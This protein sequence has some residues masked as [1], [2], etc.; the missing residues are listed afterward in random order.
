MIWILIVLVLWIG[1]GLF[2]LLQGSQK[3]GTDYQRKVSRRVYTVGETVQVSLTIKPPAIV[4]ASNHDVILAIDDSDSMGKAPGSPLR[5]VIRAAENFIRLLPES[6]HIG[7]VSFDQNAYVLCPLTKDHNQSIQ[8]LNAV[9][10]SSGTSIHLALDRCREVL[11]EGRDAVGKTVILLSDGYSNQELAEES[12]RRLREEVPGVTI[13]C[14]AFGTKIDQTL[15]K[16]VANSPGQYV[17]IEDVT[18]GM[19]QFFR[20]LAETMV[21]RVAAGI[22][23]EATWTPEAFRLGQTSGLYPAGIYPENPTRIIWAVPILSGEPVQLTYELITRCPGWR[24]VASPVSNA[25]WHLANG[26]EQLR[27]GQGRPKILV[28][29]W[30]MRWGW[31]LFNPLFWMAFGRWWPCPQPEKEVQQETEISLLPIPSLPAVL[32]AP[33]Q[34]LYQPAFRPALVIGLGEIGEWTVCRLKHRVHDR[35]ID[36]SQAGFLTIRASHKSNYP[37]IKF[38]GTVV[39]PDESIEIHQDLRPY[40]ESLRNNGSPPLRTW[41]PW[42]QWLAD[43]RPLTTV[44][45]VA[46][47][48]RKARLALLRQPESVEQKLKLA[49]ERIANTDNGVVI[50]VGAAHDAECSGMLA[51]VAH[52]CA[53]KGVGVTAVLAPTVI[54]DEA[55]TSVL[56][57]VEEIERMVL[58]AGRSIASDRQDPPV[59]AKQLFDRVIVLEQQAQDREQASAPAA[60]FI[61]D[62]LAYDKVFQR[63][64]AVQTSRQTV[65]CCRAV[66]DGQALPAESLWEWVR[67][68]TLV[69]GI[70][71]QRL[72]LVKK[73]GKFTLPK[74]RKEDIENDVEEFWTARGSTRPAS[75]LLINSRAILRSV[76]A[77]SVAELVGLQDQLPVNEPYHQQATYATRERE[78]FARYVEGWCYN[79]LEREQSKGNWGLQALAVAL[80]QI[81]ANFNLILN[82]V[83]RNSNRSSFAELAAFASSIYV[84]FLNIISALRSDLLHW[85]INLTGAQFELNTTAT[86]T[87]ERPSVC[88]N[89]EY[90]KNKSEEGLGHLDKAAREFLEDKLEG[91]YSTYGNNLLGRLH[92]LI[93]LEEKSNQLQ[94]RLRLDEK[95]ELQS[96]Q[97]ISDAIRGM[98]NEYRNVVLNWQLEQL[99]RPESVSNP[100]DRFRIGQYSSHIYPRVENLIDE[101]DP[102]TAAAVEIGERPL[103]EALG[104][105]R[106]L[107][108]EK[109]YIWPEEA[110][111][112]RI[113][114]KI[115]HRL[116]R[117]PQIF[118]SMVVHLL[119][120]TGKL[121][122]FFNDLAEDRVESTGTGFLLR[123]GGQQFEIGPF[124]E[125]LTGFEAFQNVVQQVV[126]FEISL[127]GEPIHSSSPIWK[128]DP[129]DAIC[130]VEKHPLAR[131]AMDS[132]EWRMWRDVIRG[133]VLEHSDT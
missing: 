62:M 127:K 75:P 14:A 87:S 32:P 118:T 94:I 84:D 44:R 100:V 39:A 11:R 33:Q 122:E 111:A 108:G 104:V 116:K 95:R 16:S 48:R 77:N 65:I 42:R 113:S 52:I 91:W 63:I 130:A 76:N 36:P 101:E 105:A 61:W 56:A 132:P 106:P 46:G 31:L 125:N 83:S 6:I 68:C 71:E 25:T 26:T 88:Y 55:S 124:P 47:D 131:E 119:R 22:I 128:I 67:E 59:S 133:L 17:H 89:I 40:L 112:A 54:G 79:L 50:L 9:T 27:G 18:D 81:E 57:F 49:L 64:P 7:I 78:N 92:F 69:R 93:R 35:Q 60:E 126:A 19:Y 10:S 129:E 74:L 70:N 41:V 66:I 109:P 38:K 28:L 3:D 107:K 21:G 15:L 97:D 1:V 34:K 12:A 102:F 99:I 58:M 37:Q 29:P 45:S 73:Q 53:T 115:R 5:E 121:F 2:L 24:A 96:N 90:A 114:E 72:G 110:N 117:D 103:R 43:R 13:I 123:R 86:P 30:W 82:R 85:I 51:E 4:P 120:D 80:L 98:L 23:E 8:A 20:L